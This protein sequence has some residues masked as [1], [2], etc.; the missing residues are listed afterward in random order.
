MKRS[1]LAADC[2]DPYVMQTHRQTLEERARTKRPTRSAP[3]V[4]HPRPSRTGLRRTKAM[5]SSDRVALYAASRRK[6][7][8]A[9]T[10]SSS[11]GA[12]PR[13]AAGALWSTSIALLGRMAPSSGHY[14]DLTSPCRFQSLSEALFAAL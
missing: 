8:P 11:S 14:F 9:K 2:P 10:S 1:K 6:T 12:T 7:R 13:R 3:Y 4:M 5:K